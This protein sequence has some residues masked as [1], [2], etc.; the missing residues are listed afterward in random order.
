MTVTV[1]RADPPP[2]GMAAARHARDGLLVIVE[3]RLQ[4][5]PG[6]GVFEL[7]GQ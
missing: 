6:V 2:S 7:C 3:W 4:M 5:C 1:L